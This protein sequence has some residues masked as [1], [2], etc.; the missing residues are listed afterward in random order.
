[1]IL[2]LSNIDDIQE[3]I[4]FFISLVPKPAFTLIIYSQISS[5]AMQYALQHFSKKAVRD[6][7][8]NKLSVIK[9][10]HIYPALCKSRLNSIQE[11]V[12]II[13]QTMR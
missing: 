9:R 3:T 7:K 1:M 4:D 6:L 11:E 2:P 13:L 5:Y 10:L 8:R 12:K